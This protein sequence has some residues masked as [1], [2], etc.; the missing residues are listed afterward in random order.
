MFSVFNYGLFSYTNMVQFNKKI[1]AGIKPPIYGGGGN[2]TA[3]SA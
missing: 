1:C 3:G 2:P